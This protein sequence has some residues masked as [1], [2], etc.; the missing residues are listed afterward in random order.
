VAGKTAKMSGMQTPG[1]EEELFRRFLDLL[2]VQK[3]KPGLDALNEIVSAHVNRIPFENISKL[4]YKKR[5]NLENI[6]RFDM[7]IEG[8]EK[9]RFGG[10][11]YANNYYMNRLLDWLGYEVKLCG[12]GMRALDAH[13]VTIAKIEDREFLVDTG[14]AAPFTEAIPLDLSYNYILELGND[15][16]VLKPWDNNKPRQLELYRNGV[17]SHGYSINPMPRHIGEFKQ[18]IADSYNAAATFMNAL[19]LT[20]FDASHFLII[21]NMTM[22]EARGIV[23]N[24]YPLGST[25]QLISTIESRFGIPAEIVKESLTRLNM[26]GDAWN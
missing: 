6:P 7:Y 1:F 17:L 23:A 16:Y 4:Y 20:R 5:L 2:G 3:Q 26:Q 12:A 11:C 14:Y 21:H 15:S 13:I 10:T 22:T 19:L 24:N 8:V 18:V 9:Y 25:E